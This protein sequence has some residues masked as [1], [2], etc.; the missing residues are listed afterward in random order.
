[1]RDVILDTLT[2]NSGLCMDIEEERESLCDALMEAF[3][4]GQMVDGSVTESY[5]PEDEGEKLVVEVAGGRHELHPDDLD[6]RSDVYA[7]GVVGYQL[8]TGRLP[9]D[10][11]GRT[12]AEALRVIREH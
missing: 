9:Y 4:Y 2:A 8:L 11:R 7:L 3:G 10:L 12:L 1:M 6:I 5:P